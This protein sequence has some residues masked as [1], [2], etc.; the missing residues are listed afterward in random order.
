M[1]TNAQIVAHIKKLGTLA[2]AECNRRISQGKGFALPSV[3]IAQS[4]LETGWGTSSIMTKANAFF[5]I[6]AG[7]SWTG[8]VFTADTWEV[9]DGVAYNTRA[10]FRAYDRLEDSVRDYYDFVSA[11]RYKAG[12]SYGTD[13]SAW[14]S[15]KECVT[16]FWA[17]GYATDTLY[18]QK[19]MN[20]INPRNLT[21]WDTKIDG[22]TFSDLP[23]DHSTPY[24]SDIKFTRD[25]FI[26]GKL[27]FTDSGRSIGNDT[28]DLNAVALDWDKSIIVNQ[29]IYSPDNA[30]GTLQIKGTNTP[31]MYHIFK[32]TGDSPT[33]LGIYRYGETFNAT[34]G[35]R[36]GLYL[37][38]SDG[39]A[40]SP[41]SL[42]ASFNITLVD[43]RYIDGIDNS[44]SYSSPIAHFIKVE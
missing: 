30:T 17:G 12:L 43:P 11:T 16:A 26:Q 25:N 23:T 22:V 2:V 15:A 9:K 21:E 28:T 4:A 40:L 29:R 36:I 27:I 37:T 3:C 6:K 18:V 13:P 34:E 8:K 7:G 32:L 41:D 24:F 35:E 42:P 33:E 1:A 19:I 44:E 5:G 38:L 39:S 31:Y 20:H 14:L 10:N